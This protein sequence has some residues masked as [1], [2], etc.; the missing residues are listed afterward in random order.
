MKELEDKYISLSFPKIKE[1]ILKS[2]HVKN[3]IKLERKLNNE[4]EFEESK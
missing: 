4:E 3:I 1:R 2:S